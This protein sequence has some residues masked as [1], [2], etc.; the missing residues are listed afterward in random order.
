MLRMIFKMTS[1]DSTYDHIHESLKF[2]YLIVFPLK[3]KVK[4][5]HLITI[6]TKI[7][8]SRRKHT[9]KIKKFFWLQDA[10][11]NCGKNVVDITI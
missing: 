7:T 10:T 11:R 8:K 5:L 1:T 2:E 4:L 6:T 3:S 9:Q